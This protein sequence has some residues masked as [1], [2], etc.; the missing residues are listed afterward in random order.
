MPLPQARIDLHQLEATVALVPL[1]LHLREAVVVERTE[2]AQRRVDDLLHP[3]RFADTARADSGGRLLQ[4]PP[5]EDAER[6]PVP[7]QIAADAVEGAVSARDEL[8]HHRLELLRACVGPLQLARRL[9][10]ERLPPETPLEADR[11]AR[12]HERREAELLSGRP[13]LGRRAGMARLR[14]VE[15]GSGLPLE[16]RALALNVHEPIPRRKG[17]QQGFVEV[18][19]ERVQRRVVG[20]EDGQGRAALPGK[21]PHRLD[22]PGLVLHRIGDEDG[23]RIPRAEAE[24]ARPVVERKHP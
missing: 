10:P 15:S 18:P 23:L 21:R 9:A 16:L 24:R 7:G 17:S 4:L 12:L 6:A 1:E 20:R 8:L 13:C 11:V 3:D 19:G 5:A 22:E 14:D 2:Q